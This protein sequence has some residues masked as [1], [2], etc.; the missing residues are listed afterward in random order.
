MKLADFLARFDFEYEICSANEPDEEAHRLRLV[1]K[2]ELAE[3]DVKKL[4]FRLIDRRGA[5][6]GGIEE[7]RFALDAGFIEHLVERLDICTK[8]FGIQHGIGREIADA[9]LLPETIVL[10]SWYSCWFCG[11]VIKESEAELWG[12]IQMKHPEVFKDLQDLD[13][14]DMMEECYRQL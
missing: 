7:E 13:T 2:G 4:L 3:E 10:E 5:N 12:H 9:V 8:N 6:I 14:P 1:E 11:E